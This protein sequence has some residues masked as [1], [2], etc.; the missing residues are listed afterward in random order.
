MNNAVTAGAM[1]GMH[2]SVSGALQMGMGG[3]VLDNHPAA[4]M[5]GLGASERQFMI[6]GPDS[7]E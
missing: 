2:A 6:A 1:S 3:R 4:L 5:K 7:G